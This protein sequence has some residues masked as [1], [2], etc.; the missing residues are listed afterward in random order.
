MLNND[1]KHNTVYRKQ[2]AVLGFTCSVTFKL[3]MLPKYLFE[4]AGRNAWIAAAILMVVELLVGLCV[5]FCMSRGSFF[6]LPIAKWFKYFVAVVMILGVSARAIV[7]LSEA[8]DYVNKILF[9]EGVWT[10]KLLAL[11]ITVFFIAFKGAK[12]IAR[13]AQITFFLIIISS[14][15]AIITFNADVQLDNIYPILTDGPEGVF[16]TMNRHMTWFGD[17]APLMFFCLADK[18]KDNDKF[19]VPTTMI[20]NY[21]VVVGF[22]ILLTGMYGDSGVMLSHFFVDLTQFTVADGLEGIMFPLLICWIMMAVVRLSMAFFCGI[23]C[24]QYLVKNRIVSTAGNFILIFSMMLYLGTVKQ[25]Y[26]IATSNLRYLIATLQWG[27]PIGVA[28]YLFIKEKL[29]SKKPDKIMG[30]MENIPTSA[31][32]LE[33]A[34]ELGHITNKI[35]STLMHPFTSGINYTTSVM[36][37]PKQPEKAGTN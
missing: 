31:T 19:V 18:K 7:Y 27:L 25:T 30:D 15:I 35:I 20:I 28:L 2:L 21:L 24:G 26:D 8:M 14:V 17:C 33:I 5:V 13:V 37:Y 4:G 16:Y 22:M 23:E 36:S 11:L 3:L 32:N 9:E 1:R 12:V 29:K 34:Q 10:F 6:Q